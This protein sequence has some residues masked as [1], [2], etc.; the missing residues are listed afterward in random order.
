MENKYLEKHGDLNPKEQKIEVA[1]FSFNILRRSVEKISKEEDRVQVMEFVNEL[2]HYCQEYVKI[3]ERYSQAWD[4]VKKASSVNPEDRE[5]E[6]EELEIWMQAK[7]SKKNVIADD[8]NILSRLF[9]NYALDT[10]WYHGFSNEAQFEEW[11]L[12]RAKESGN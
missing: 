1:Q 12:G 6:L 2:E 9:K 5:N 7:I 8:L 11:I 4:E 3:D 10:S